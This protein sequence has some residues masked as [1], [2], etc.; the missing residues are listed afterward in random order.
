[1]SSEPQLA[2][3]KASSSD[4]SVVTLCQACQKAKEKATKEKA[5]N[6][7]GE[8][9]VVSVGDEGE[10]EGVGDEGEGDEWRRSVRL[11][12]IETEKAKAKNEKKQKKKAEKD[13]AKEK[14]E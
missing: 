12:L 1:M 4:M 6:G 5:T 3:E 7:E 10:V 2:D 8:G 14:A 11:Y 9:D 13:K